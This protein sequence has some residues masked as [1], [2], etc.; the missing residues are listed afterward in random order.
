MTANPGHSFPT[1]YL[2]GADGGTRLSSC[3]VTVG[4]GGRTAIVTQAQ[5]FENV[6]GQAQEVTYALPRQASGAILEMSV[7]L[8][9]RTVRLEPRPAGEAQA[10]YEAAREGGD[11]PVLF[12]DLGEGVQCLSLGRL[13]PGET[14]TTTIKFAIPIRLWDRQGELRIPTTVAPRF[15]APGDALRSTFMADPSLL[16]EHPLDL[17]VTVW[18]TM[19]EVEVSSPTHRLRAGDETPERRTF[20]LALPAFKD[21]D[22]VL[23]LDGIPL[24]GNGRVFKDPVGGGH[25]AIVD[26][27][28]TADIVPKSRDVHIL[29]D[30]SGSMRGDGAETVRGILAALAT[31]LGGRDTVSLSRFGSHCLPVFDRRR[32][33]ETC[34]LL[35]QAADEIRGNMGGTN[36]R[37]ALEQ[38]LAS[39]RPGTDI[40]LLSDGLV[41][42]GGA[43]TD[44]LREGRHRLFAVAVGAAPRADLLQA[45]P[46]ETGGTALFAAPGDAPGPLAE[47]IARR[48]ATPERR[49]SSFAWE[50]AEP[51]WCE[52][53]GQA[54]FTG[55]TAGVFARFS[56][57]ATP[58][59]FCA[60]IGDDTNVAIDL[61]A[62][63]G[64]GLDMAKLVAQRQHGLEDDPKR[65]EEISVRH[66]LVTAEVSLVGVVEREKK[67]LGETEATVIRSM[68]AAGYGGYGALRG[69]D[70]ILTG[71]DDPATD[72][73]MAPRQQGPVIR[74][75]R[76]RRRTEGPGRDRALGSVFMSR[77][78]D[79]FAAPAEPAGGTPLAFLSARSWE[80]AK[81][82]LDSGL[83]RVCERL[84][85][86]GWAADDLWG[87]LRAVLLSRLGRRAEDFPV[88]GAP[89]THRVLEDLFGRLLAT[90]SARRWRLGRHG[91]GRD[92]GLAHEAMKGPPGAGDG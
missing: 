61:S 31:R 12:E 7:T 50:G 13:A 67:D 66:G 10:E 48:L 4:I 5:T 45:L 49:L 52:P 69:G 85:A 64:D 20:T 40:L 19:R 37:A 1:G 70:D 77:H 53:A 78:D 56:G 87:A 15:G 8:G 65:R 43:V 6:S 62:A 39:A 83:S 27:A 29:A 26:I 68:M 92:R 30:C 3:V 23:R 16:A 88:D 46:A 51:E 28:D 63:A 57:E 11:L 81:R 54:V 84:E 18:G 34:R 82:A 75:A 9:G 22:I 58:T 59:R 71:L 21:R 90:S 60:R 17:R 2:L 41:H 91:P 89:G 47:E 55:V 42:Q 36:L 76:A 32:G 38:A 73:W 44:R 72:R 24:D 33:G 35:L 25:V 14:V 80:D 79:R 86:A 74:G